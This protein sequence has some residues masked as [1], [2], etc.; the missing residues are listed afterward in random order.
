MAH[1][2]ALRWHLVRSAAVIAILCCVAFFFSDFII[3]D[4]LMAPRNPNFPT[5]GWMCK[6]GELVKAKDAI[7]IKVDPSKK[8]QFLEASAPF[9]TYMWICLL[10]GIIVGFPYFLWELWKFIR[11]ALR[12]TETKPVRGFVL[13]GTLLFLL[14][15]LFG[16]FIIFPLS[17]NFLINFQLS[18]KQHTVMNNTADDYISLITTLS[19]VAGLVFELPIVVYFLTRLGIFSPQFMRKYRRHAVVVLLILSAVITPSPDV[20]SQLIVFTPLFLLYE[21]SIFVS[22]G[23]VK[24][25][26]REMGM[27]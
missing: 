8:L 5:Y 21:I 17:Y 4:I 12:D 11:P 22:A 7:C 9:T 18:A 1:L 13:V 25:R 15:I 26:N 10:A 6:L 14:G 19:M 16:Y 27:S 2:E 24:R 23:V 20:M 3:D